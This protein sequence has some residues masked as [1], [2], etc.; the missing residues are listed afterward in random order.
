VTGQAAQ[1]AAM[2]GIDVPSEVEGDERFRVALSDPRFGRVV[3]GGGGRRKLAVTND[4]RFAGRLT[5]L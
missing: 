3:S 4:E 2:G 5:L 1:R